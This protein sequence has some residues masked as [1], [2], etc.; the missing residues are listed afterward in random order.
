MTT[1]KEKYLRSDGMLC[2]YCES[3]NLDGEEEDDEHIT[4][5]TRIVSCINCGKHWRDVYTL[6]DIEE[7]D[8]N[9]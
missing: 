8:D 5:I 2:P 3:N 4:T 9:E 6:T 7:L 1:L